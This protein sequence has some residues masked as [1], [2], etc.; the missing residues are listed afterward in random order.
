VFDGRENYT[1]RE[2][3]ADVLLVRASDFRVGPGWRWRL[4]WFVHTRVYIW[5]LWLGSH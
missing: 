2:R 5:R 3:P 4:G 1:G